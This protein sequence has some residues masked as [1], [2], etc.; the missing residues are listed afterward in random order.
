MDPAAVLLVIRAASDHQLQRRIDALALNSMR[1]KIS[2][3]A[4]HGVTNL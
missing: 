2:C 3:D 4:A 1:S